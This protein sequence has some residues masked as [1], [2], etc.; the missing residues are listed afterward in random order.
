MEN[1]LI[2]VSLTTTL[3]KLY[4]FTNINL[5]DLKKVASSFIPIKQSLPAVKCRPEKFTDKRFVDDRFNEQQG[6]NAV[7]RTILYDFGRNMMKT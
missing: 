2:L 4:L 5:L 7:D 6:D 1:L 3:L